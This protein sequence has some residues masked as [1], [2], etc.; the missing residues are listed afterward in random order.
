MHQLRRTFELILVEMPTTLEMRSLR[1][2]NRCSSV[3]CKAGVKGMIYCKAYDWLKIY[4][5]AFWLASRFSNRFAIVLPD[6]KVLIVCPLHFSYTLFILLSTALY[7]QQ[8]SFP[9]RR[10]VFVDCWWRCDDHTEGWEVII[11]LPLS[12]SYYEV[13]SKVI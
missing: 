12:P 9:L 3:I 1:A 4:F 2:R 5:S 13:D 6:P 10:N 8:A 11:S 7:T